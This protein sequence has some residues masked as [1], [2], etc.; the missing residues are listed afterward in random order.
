MT[1]RHDCQGPPHQRAS[2]TRAVLG[3]IGVSVHFADR[4]ISGVHV[5]GGPVLVAGEFHQFVAEHFGESWPSGK[6]WMCFVRDHTSSE[7]EAFDLFFGLMDEYDQ[8]E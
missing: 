4:I 3:H 1:T 5:G 6:G 7:R 8:K 2:E